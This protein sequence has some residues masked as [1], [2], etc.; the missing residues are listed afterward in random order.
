M[1]INVAHADDHKLFRM[2]LASSLKSHGE[3]HLGIQASNG[4]ELIERIIKA[5]KKPDIILMDIRM[6]I[7][8]GIEATKFIKFYKPEI[9]II[10]LT[11]YDEVNFAREFQNLGAEGYLL[12]I[13]ESQEIIE[14]IVKVYQGHLC[15][16]ILN[17]KDYLL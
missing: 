5:P 15:F 17:R 6:P 13:V 9:K 1:Q 2:G 8:S 10:A 4:E 11:M 16:D 7:M 14:T 3:I 12:K